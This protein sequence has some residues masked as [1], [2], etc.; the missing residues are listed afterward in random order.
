MFLCDCDPTLKS[1]MI[2]KAQCSAQKFSD[3]SVNKN[4]YRMTEHSSI[5]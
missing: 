4:G 1:S 3:V 2:S 5:V